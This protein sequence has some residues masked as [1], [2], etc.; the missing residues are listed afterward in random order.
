MPK[1][2]ARS[3]RITRALHILGAGLWLAACSGGG[4]GGGGSASGAGSTAATPAQT[5]A[6]TLGWTGASGPVAGYSVYVQRGSSDFKHEADVP[7]T[8][9]QVYGAP[10]STARVIV[11]AYDSVHAHGPVSPSSVQFV[12]PTAASGQGSAAANAGFVGTMAANIPASAP[13]SAPTTSTTSDPVSDPT[14]SDPPPAETPEQTPAPDLPG[15]ALVWQSGDAFRLTN[16]AVE[17]TRLFARPAAGAQLAGVADFDGDGHGDLLWASSSGSLAYVP[18]SVLRGSEPLALV[19]LGTTATTAKVLGAGDFDGDGFGDVLI[20]RNGGIFARLTRPSA[21]VDVA[22]LGSS[23]GAPLAGIA[24][25][26]ANGSDDIAWRTPDALVVWLMNGGHASGTVTVDLAI[27]FDVIGIGDFDGDGAAEVATRDASGSVLV[28]HPLAAQPAFEATDLTNA[29]GW[30]G[31]GAV[32]F[33][34]DH[35]DELV[36]ASA[37][38]IR[39]AGLPGDQMVPLDPAS[40]WRLVALLP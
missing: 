4:G 30:T 35:S 20:E 32:D 34:P 2:T 8:R 17:T 3:L 12:F 38:A 11:V 21:A 15:G 10:G 28:L 6:V 14:A 39:L 33:E 19:S 25:F 22:D 13:S 24:D 16:A 37:E 29:Q 9:A 5:S 18:G 7:Q 27:D 23:A 1:S 26:D 36:L 40:P 31:V